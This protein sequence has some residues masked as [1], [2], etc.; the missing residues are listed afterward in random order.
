[1][2]SYK[3]VVCGYIVAGNELPEDR[4]C[5]KCKGALEKIATPAAPQLAGSKTE[6]NLQAAFAGESQARNK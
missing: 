4:K 3:C 6:A 1:M 5:P 2:D